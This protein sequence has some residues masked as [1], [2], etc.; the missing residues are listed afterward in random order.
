MVQDIRF[1]ADFNLKITDD[2]GETEKTGTGIFEM[3]L[4]RGLQTV[5]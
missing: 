1:N 3:M 4:L 5:R 2:T